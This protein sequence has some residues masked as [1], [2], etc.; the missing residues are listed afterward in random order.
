[1]SSRKRTV[2]LSPDAQID[3]TDILLFTWQQ[4]SEEQR[5][6]YEAALLRAIARLADY[7]EVG[8]RR[9]GL[10][11]GCRAHAVGRH[12]LYYRFKDDI[13]EVVRI[14]H[15]RTDPTRHLRP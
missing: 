14:L 7:P 8:E 3:F 6:Q 4:G 13:V 5:D 12:I 9:H 15:E 2:I 10:F 1:M 11:S